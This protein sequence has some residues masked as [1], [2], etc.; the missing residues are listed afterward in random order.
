M[1][2]LLFILTLLPLITFSQIPDGTYKYAKITITGGII[3]AIDSAQEIDPTVDIDV[4]N[5]TNTDLNHWNDAYTLISSGYP[6][7][8]LLDYLINH[9]WIPQNTDALA[10]GVTNQY[11]SIAKFNAALNSKTTDNLSEGLVNKYYSNSLA[12]NAI[13][14]NSPLGYNSGTGTISIVTANTSQAGIISAADWNIFNNKQNALG[15]TPVPNS[16]TLTINGVTQDQTNNR[17][18]TI[19]D[20]TG[21]SGTATALQ[22]ARNING[23]PF[24]GTSNITISASPTISAPVAGI[25][26]T[27][28][29]PFQPRAG[30]P[31]DIIIN[32]NVSG[33]VG[34]G[35]TIVI[36][37][38]P[39]SGGTYTNVSTDGVSITILG[40]GDKASSTI[41]VPTGYYV[42]VTYTP[43]GLATITGTYTRW[44]L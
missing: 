6:N 43:T 7:Y 12:R 29:T 41:H 5:I 34:V 27:S 9:V 35:G 21:N 40:I 17:T 16:R 18:W 14:V 42:R 33:L 15:F 38:S 28:G 4:K 8:T 32:T 44:D 20:I 37:T 30:G 11:Y 2:F 31:C 10:E 3:S 25:S 22:T 23:V 24:D 13:S 1:K 39:T 36:A 26:L 19:S